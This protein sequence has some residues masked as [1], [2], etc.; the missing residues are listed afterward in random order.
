MVLKNSKRS[1]QPHLKYGFRSLC[2]VRWWQPV[3]LGQMQSGGK[4]SCPLR[5]CLED[6]ED[7]DDTIWE[8]EQWTGKMKRIQIFWLTKQSWFR[9]KTIK[10]AALTRDR[11]FIFQCCKSQLPKRKYFCDELGGQTRSHSFLNYSESMRENLINENEEN[12][13]KELEFL[14]GWDGWGGH[15]NIATDYSDLEYCW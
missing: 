12:L 4:A 6:G 9:R 13:L 3:S 5:L 11:F 10:I 8:T 15:R 7:T 1:R 2:S 14:S